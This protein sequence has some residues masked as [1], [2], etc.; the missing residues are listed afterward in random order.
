L[1]KDNVAI[2]RGN[3]GVLKLRCRG[4]RS[5]RV[6]DDDLPVAV[7]LDAFAAR[8]RRLGRLFLFNGRPGNSMCSR[9][10]GD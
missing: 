6:L 2:A 7:D 9:R 3:E 10:G 8:L 1:G 4:D 5:I